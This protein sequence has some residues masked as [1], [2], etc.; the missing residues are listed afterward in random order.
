MLI[1]PIPDTG[2]EVDYRYYK[3]PNNLQ[4]DID[5]PDIPEKYHHVVVDGGT[6]RMMQYKQQQAASQQYQ[7]RYEVGLQKMI[8]DNR[9]SVT[10]IDQLGRYDTRFHRKGD[11]VVPF[12]V[13]PT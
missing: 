6:Y 8:E 10:R 11:I 3:I 9:A 7:Q 5:Y 12:P 2:Y 13:I 1:D 4:N